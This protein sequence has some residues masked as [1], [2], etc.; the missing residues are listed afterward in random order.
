MRADCRAELRDVLDPRRAAEPLTLHD[1]DLIHSDRFEG[2]E[3]VN[4][5][6]G[7]RH[8]DSAAVPGECVDETDGG[9][10]EVV[11]GVRRLRE[12]EHLG[13]GNVQQVGQTPRHVGLRYPAKLIVLSGP[14]LHAASFCLSNDFIYRAPYADL[15]ADR[16]SILSTLDD[17]SLQL[18]HRLFADGAPPV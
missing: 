10:E 2:F 9:N 13:I 11:L 14:N 7:A 16:I 5:G 4:R 8:D 3:Q 6:M 15:V 18:L 12:Q 17:E 1:P